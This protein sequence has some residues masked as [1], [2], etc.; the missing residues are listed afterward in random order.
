MMRIEQNKAQEPQRKQ[1]EEPH[2]VE[3]SGVLYSSPQLQ[4]E[5]SLN[6]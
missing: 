2:L 6:R 5:Q 4:S 1:A 3:L